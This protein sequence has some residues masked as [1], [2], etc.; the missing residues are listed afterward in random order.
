MVPRSMWFSIISELLCISNLKIFSLYGS[1]HRQ[2]D[3]HAWSDIFGGLDFWNLYLLKLIVRLRSQ[4][5][6]FGTNSPL[7]Q[8]VNLKRE[9]NK[10]RD[11]DLSI[12]P[13]DQNEVDSILTL[14]YNDFTITISNFA[15]LCVTTDLGETSRKYFLHIII[16]SL[17]EPPSM[18]E[19]LEPSGSISE[20]C[21]L[22]V[23]V[24]VM[25]PICMVRSV[26]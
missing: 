20:D 17:H 26:L 14:K 24:F 4:K 25:S 12:F 1:Y 5:V 11:V 16:H 22:S 10:K 6:I 3:T 19:H 9:I 2:T 21:L 7:A 13:L 8:N 18:H 23:Y 15:L